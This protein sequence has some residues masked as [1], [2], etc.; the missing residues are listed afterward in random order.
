MNFNVQKNHYNQMRRITL[1]LLCEFDLKNKRSLQL[2]KTLLSVKDDFLSQISA[3]RLL[4]Y[5]RELNWGK[6]VR[7]R[8]VYF[9]LLFV[10]EQLDRS[11]CKVYIKNEHVVKN[12]LLNCNK[13]LD[14]VW[15]NRTSK[16]AENYSKETTE[17]YT[18]TKIKNKYLLPR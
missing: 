10:I 4:L 9:L 15:D 17:N 1:K 14:F 3:S 7:G 12:V 11:I 16:A 6:E 18:T 13:K 2:L 8:V 5:Y